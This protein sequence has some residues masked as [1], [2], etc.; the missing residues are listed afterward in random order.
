MALLPLPGVAFRVVG[1]VKRVPTGA[2]GPSVVVR[3]IPWLFAVRALL[4]RIGHAA[5]S[6][7]SRDLG[8]V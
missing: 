8:Y 4:E 3:D 6:G 2:S 7:Y 1:G 5:G